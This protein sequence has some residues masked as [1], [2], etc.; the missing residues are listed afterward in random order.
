MSYARALPAIQHRPIAEINT[1]PLIDVML[2][3]LI[4]MI[5]TIPL[6]TNAVEVDL[7]NGDGPVID[8]SLNT[9]VITRDGRILW[10]VQGISES[11]LPGQLA[12]TALLNPE[13]Q[14]RFEP[15]ATAAYG[16][17]ARVLWLIRQSGVTNFGFAGNERYRAFED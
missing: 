9:V 2:V 3:L 12:Q 5:I 4:M 6:A 13:P 17:S 15:E 7:P 8:A 14:L 10:N 1:T 11:E 16:Q